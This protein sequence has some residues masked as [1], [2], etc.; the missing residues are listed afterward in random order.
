MHR[1][2]P[3]P[4][5]AHLDWLPPQDEERLCSLCEEAGKLV[6]EDMLNLVCLLD[7]DAYA[8][9]VDAG[10]DEHPLVLVSRDGERVQDD[11]GRAR[12]L[13]FRDI[14]SLRGLRGKVGEGE[15]GCERGAHALEVR[16]Q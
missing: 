10:L 6:D 7:L 1:H 5:A 9:A 13:D 2:S 15:G 11:L 3:C 8:H 14:V 4:P 12:S 16:P